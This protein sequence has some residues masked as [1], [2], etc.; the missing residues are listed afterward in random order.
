MCK[1]SQAKIEKKRSFALCENEAHVKR[2]NGIA[3]HLSVIAVTP[4]CAWFCQENKI[5]YFRLDSFYSNEDLNVLGALTL[6]REYLWAKWIDEK[7]STLI[8]E[9]ASRGFAPARTQ[10]YFLKRIIDSYIRPS[11][12]LMDFAENAKPEKLVVFERAPFYYPDLDPLP[13]VRPFFAWLAPTIL[14][15]VV[16]I[17]VWPEPSS[18]SDQRG[19]Q[20][21]QTGLIKRVRRAKSIGFKNL[22]IRE[23]K[24][25]KAALGDFFRNQGI[26]GRF[27]NRW[28]MAYVVSLMRSRGIKV[29][30]P[31]GFWNRLTNHELEATLSKKRLEQHWAQIFELPDFW[32]V[33]D[34]VSPALRK[35]FKP[36]FEK[37]LTV[38]VPHAWT[39]FLDCRNW[40]QK[41]K[42]QVVFGMEVQTLNTAHQFMAAGS[43]GIPRIAFIHNPPSGAVDLPVQD[44][45]GPIQSD[46]YMVNG[47]GDLE[48]FRKLAERLMTFPRARNIA[49]GSKRLEQMIEQK[50]KNVTSRMPYVQE[51]SKKHRVLYVATHFLG[52]GRYFNEGAMSD[53]EYFELQQRIL[54]ACSE[55]RDV[56]ILYKP[57]PSES[58]ENPIPKFIR[59][60]VPNAQIIQGRLTELM[61]NVDGIILDFPSTA[62]AEILTTDK[63]LLIYAGNCWSPLLPPAK[64]ALRER[65]L[66]AETPDEFEDQVRLFLGERNFR[67]V[68]NKGDEFLR[69]YGV[70]LMDGRS[71]DRAAEIV[72][73]VMHNREK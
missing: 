15:K 54:N 43:L 56:Q 10:L 49:V 47:Q 59:S 9:F 39:D 66:I 28:D 58:V 45:L 33:F 44:S 70:H 64:V 2:I 36:F 3:P 6:K 32:Q 29:L 5:Q 61:W 69:L 7:L 13:P 55:F 57:F 37:W 14:G 72:F 73:Q 1:E 23:S 22:I 53:V 30:R 51:G 50:S 12:I 24:F 26:V 25:I 67:S 62:L 46:F 60:R 42:C 18:E 16:N 8:P 52:Y 41:K 34:P 19:F 4:A 11:Q 20:Y 17:E 31:P 27:G 48:Y 40:L 35:I 65:A 68:P 63:A 38:D 71:A 21:Q